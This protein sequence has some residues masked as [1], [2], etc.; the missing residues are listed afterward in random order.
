M[1]GVTLTP[2]RLPRQQGNLVH[3]DRVCSYVSLVSL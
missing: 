3:K 1:A 2:K